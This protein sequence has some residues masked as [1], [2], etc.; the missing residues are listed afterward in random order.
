MLKTL[1]IVGIIMGCVY[2]LIGLGYS[3]I[4]KASGIMNLAQGEM[5]TM[6]AFLGYT[7]NTICGL[8]Y[9]ISL[10]LTLVAMFFFGVFIQSGLVANYQKRGVTGVYMI[11]ITF[12]LS[13]VMNG[14]EAVIFGSN[15]RRFESI[16]TMSTVELL[17]ARMPPERVMCLFLA[18][19]AMLFVHLFMTKTQTGIGMQA[20]AMHPK[21]AEACGINV[22]RSNAITWGLA[23]LVAGLCGMMLGPTYGLTLTLGAG[24]SQM[25]FAS[26]VS[27]GMG[28]I[29]GAII[30]GIIIGL[31]ES[32]V[33]GYVNPM[34]K[35][36]VAYIVLFV[37]LAVRPTGLFNETTVRDV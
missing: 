17:G 25:G 5:I 19:A 4:Y 16:F 34:M 8:P 2:G 30:G 24:L 3:I 28:N 29:Y 31:V 36:L 10:V 27:G 33:G 37:I 15:P 14:T 7:F 18:V 11:L 32:L 21:A 20:C 35:S 6:A 26:S 22:V 12:G 13:R 1:I 23:S 9:W